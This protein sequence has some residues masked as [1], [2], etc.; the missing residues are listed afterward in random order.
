MPPQLRARALRDVRNQAWK[1]LAQSSESNYNSPFKYE[2]LN[3]PTRFANLLP[4][5]KFVTA[6]GNATE[7]CLGAAQIPSLAAV[8]RDAQ[9]C[10]ALC[11]CPR[12]AL[13]PAGQG[14]SRLAT[15]TTQPCPAVNRAV[16]ADRCPWTRWQEREPLLPYHCPSHSVFFQNCSLLP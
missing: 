6:G 5:R 11:C 15:A 16:C 4:C 12:S 13:I 10:S 14:T 3:F 9:T 8:G 2:W 7:H 1:L